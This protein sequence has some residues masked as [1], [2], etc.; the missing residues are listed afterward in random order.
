[1]CDTYAKRSVSR[2]SG[3]TKA[4][5]CWSCFIKRIPLTFTKNSARMLCNVNPVFKKLYQNNNSYLKKK[6]GVPIL[7]DSGVLPWSLFIYVSECSS[8][9][10]MFSWVLLVLCYCL[11]TWHYSNWHS[12]SNSHTVLVLNQFFIHLVIETVIFGFS[13]IN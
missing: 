6:R 12:L 4:N 2:G 1:M 11:P 3:Q 7:K 10:L 9:L 13:S 5:L 8:I